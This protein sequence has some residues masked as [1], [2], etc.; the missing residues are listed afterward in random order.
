MN[1]LLEYILRNI[2]QRQFFLK[3]QEV[4][5]QFRT[6]VRQGTAYDTSQVVCETDASI[7]LSSQWQATAITACWV[8]PES[9]R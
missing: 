2:I 9:C 4:D 7:P 8:G 5:N 6:K 1:K 3:K